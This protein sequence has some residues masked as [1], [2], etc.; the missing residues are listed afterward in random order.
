MVFFVIEKEFADSELERLRELFSM[1]DAKL[2]EI[3]ASINCSTDPDS[4]GLCDSG[5]YF[6]GLGFVAI[7]QYLVETILFTGLSK[8]EAFKLGPIHTSGVTCVSLINAC[9]NWWKHEPEWWD[10]GEVPKMGE[11]AFSLVSNVTESHSYQMSN[12]LASFCEE[13]ELALGC[14]IPFLEEWRADVHDRREK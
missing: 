7:Q 4:D 1:L 13:S 2:A 12:V 9:A 11:K 10:A 6:I 3:S 14:L 8:T 5:E